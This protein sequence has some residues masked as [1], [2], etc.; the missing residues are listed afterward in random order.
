MHYFHY[1]NNQL[2]CEDVRVGD[3][4]EKIGS[5]CYV[6]SLRTIIEH[7][8]KL[9]SAF[10]EL[11]PLICY[12][13]KANSNLAVCRALV[14]EGAGL[15]VV[16][17][18][19]L[20]RALKIKTDP[21]KIVFAG[22]GK[23]GREIREAMKAGILFFNVESE[24]ELERIQEL[25]I[26]LR[27]SV[28]VCLRIN[29]EVE[30]HTHHYIRTAKKESKFG[31][32]FSAARHILL[33]R[34]RFF[35]VNIKGLH[36]HIGSQITQTRPYVQAVKKI[37]SFIKEMKALGIQFEYFNL[38]GGMGIV[39]KNKE[40]AQTAHVL[41]RALAP[42][43]KKL[44]LKII[45]EP[46]R[47]IVGSAGILVSRVTYVK[48]TKA[49]NFA[50]MDCGMNDLIRPSLYEAYHDIVPLQKASAQAT[51]VT[52]DVVGPICEAGDFLAKD[53]AMPLLEGG[54]FLA[55]M[56]AG[57]YGF[58]MSSNYNSRPRAAE[59][60]VRGRKFFLIRKR[61]RY[62]DLVRKERISRLLQLHLL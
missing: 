31:L 32:S 34:G 40:E 38:G 21:R 58:S 16:S 26:R 50:I 44:G 57:A 46:G 53:R 49:K 30:A 6:Y 2:C 37:S 28:D 42:M 7:F 20:Y 62:L 5:P 1:K 39:Y 14:K 13:M 24:A 17:G 59:V 55:V 36:I 56:G 19:E 25:C 54:E 10:K 18:G 11:N 43:L 23:T 12:S 45:L 27:C 48:K 33:N 22:V 47:F 35:N 9:K 8:R 61:E 60:L 4:V 52:Y 29:P 41:A 51:R 15:D 3:I